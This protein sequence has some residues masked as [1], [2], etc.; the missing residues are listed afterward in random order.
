MAQSKVIDTVEITLPDNKRFQ[1][2]G[3]DAQF[4]YEFLQSFLIR[5][6][7]TEVKGK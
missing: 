4:V 2:K 7:A 5:K 3:Q 6:T 1:V